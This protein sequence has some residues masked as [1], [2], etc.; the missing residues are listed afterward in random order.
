MEK[1]N[2]PTQE[3]RR[4]WFRDAAFGMFIHWGVYSVP[5]RGEWVMFQE[6]IPPDE[7]A[8]YAD[9]FN[10]QRYRPQEWVALAQQAGMKY[11]VLTTRHH[12]GFS[13][14][15]SKVSDFTSTKTAAKRDLIA[16]Y[17][18][19][20]RKLGMRIGFYYSLIDWRRPAAH[21]GPEKNPRGW[22]E[23]VKYVHAQVEELCTNYGKIDILWYDGGAY[24]TNDKVV[25][26]S[27]RHWNARKLN[28]MARKHQ[29]GILI[30]DRSRLRE[31]FDTPEQK[32]A[33]SKPGRLWE[34]CMT[35]NGHW[36]YTRADTLWK[37]SKA[38]IHNLTACA[39]GAGNYLLNVGPKSDG[40]IP[41]PCASRL[42]AMGRWLK[43]NGEAIY[44]CESTTLGAG[45]AGVV[46]AKGH[47]LY[48]IVHWWPG[49]ELT[50][51]RV[52]EKIVSARILQTGQELDLV[53]KGERLILRNLPPR[54]PDPLS[55]TIVMRRA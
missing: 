4:R 24:M 11:M 28:A 27:A 29:P 18:E 49:R 30:N 15:D 41:A 52:R 17:V 42:R 2:V 9:R 19:A 54:A 20:C 36:G 32:I 50:L 14:F 25:L 48:L 1:K 6:K 55:T 44:G 47:H 3:E 13:L 43:V 35:I 26:T 10:P 38:L 45:T 53:R 22:R 34:S 33:A 21:Q 8:R 16:E 37:S 46:T 39:C 23:L 12:D 31:D 51:P 7:Y 40:T 5:A